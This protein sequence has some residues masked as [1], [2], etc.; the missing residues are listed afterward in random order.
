MANVTSQ[1]L[2]LAAF[3]LLLVGAGLVGAFGSDWRKSGYWSVL[4]MAAASVAAWMLGGR[5]LSSD[6]IET[7]GLL[8]LSPLGASLTFRVDRLSAVFLLLVPFIGLLSMLYAVEYMN[9]VHRKHSP[10]AYYPFALLLMTAILGVVTSS[11]FLFFFIFW[12]MMTLS[13]WVLVWFD[14]EDE[15]KVRAAWQYFFVTHVAAACLLIAGLVC[16]SKTGSFA[17]ADIT[18]AIG[19]IALASPGLAHLLMVLFLVGFLTKAGMFPLGG[20]L[21]LAY[22]AAPSPA[23]AAFAGSM[24]KLGIYGVIRVAFEFFGQQQLTTFWGGA[25][26]VLGTLS[27]FVGTLTALRQ[28]DAKRVLSFHI[29]GQIGYM[30]LGIGTGLFFLKSSPLLASLAFIAGLYHVINHACYKSLLFLN[31]GAPEYYVGTRDLNLMGGIGAK[32]PLTLVAAI[33]ASLS[34]SGIPPLSGFVSKWLIYSSA[35]QGGIGVPL[36]LLLAVVAM[37]ISLVTLA[38]FMKLLGAMFLGKP[39]PRADAVP[40]EAPVAM[41]VPQ[42][43]LSIVCVVL[44]VAPVLPL[45]ML[46]LAAQDVIGKSSVPTYAGLF[47]SSSAGVALGTG[48]RLMS[49]WNPPLMIAAVVVLGLVTYGISRL[50]QAKSRETAGWYGGEEALPD[51]VRYRAHGFCLPFKEIFAKVYPSLPAPSIQS[52]GFLRN[53]LNLDRWLYDPLVRTGGRVTDRI[54]RTH[55]G[56]PQLYMVWQLVGVVVVLTVLAVWTR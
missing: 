4:F 31:V 38:S 10:R 23:S 55:S 15:S 36:F 21:P 50:G 7:G 41:R 9:R 48:E 46:Y 11:D 24:T 45:S 18:R 30:L 5:A 8:T 14:R 16:F 56:A 32:M 12:E 29:I 2:L 28:D 42:V 17:F 43:A 49:V 44:G 37:F 51:E 19:E 6:T 35:I 25:I 34:I 27:V 33:I 20:W 52:M 13:S 1:Q 22:P 53:V 39:S 26:A 40:G 47:G 3:G 54:S